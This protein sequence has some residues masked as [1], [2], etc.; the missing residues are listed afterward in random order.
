MS[1]T[2][3]N[4]KDNTQPSGTHKRYK[5]PKWAKPALLGALIILG[6]WVIYLMGEIY[7]SSYLAHFG[8]NSDA[9]PSSR[10]TYQTYGTIVSI[11]NIFPVARITLLICI[12]LIPMMIIAVSFAFMLGKLKDYLREKFKLEEAFFEIGSLFIIMLAGLVVALFF[13]LIIHIFGN[14]TQKNADNM[15][16]NDE[17][18]FNM[19]I[20]NKREGH[21]F[22]YLIEDN[23]KEGK[24]MSYPGFLIAHSET[25]VALYCDHKTTEYELNG[26]HLQTDISV[27]DVSDKE[28]TKDTHNNSSKKSAAC[29]NMPDISPMESPATDS[30]AIW[31]LGSLLPDL[32][33]SSAPPLPPKRP[34]NHK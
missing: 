10:D 14:M 11:N 5:I 22:V 19:G 25:R 20:S 9:F 27:K 34:P 28:T 24:S 4:S 30:A 6:T 21:P 26:R 2:T 15:S 18:Y 7:R 31:P 8:V 32:P 29:S 17:A 16:K 3:H 12:S 23:T 13:M 33:M 1:E